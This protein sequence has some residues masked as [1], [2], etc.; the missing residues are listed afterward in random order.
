MTTPIRVL[1]C[2]DDR[3]FAEAVAANLNSRADVDVVA[4][5]GSAEETERATEQLDPHVLLVD[6]MLPD[7]D[8]LELA[9]TLLERFPEKKVIILTALACRQTA[10]AAAECGARAFLKKN[11]TLDEL[12]SAIS[13]VS[14]GPGLFANGSS[15]IRSRSS[16]RSRRPSR[17]V[18]KLTSREFEVLTLL[19]HGADSQTIATSLG[20]Q[21]NTVRTHVQ[22]ILTKL[23]VHSRLEAMALAVRKSLVTLDG[24]VSDGPEWARTVAT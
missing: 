8:G 6:V 22:S 7:G 17:Q 9:G 3:L 16:E 15:A 12:V 1:I 10:D 14:A 11:A 19:V 24:P 2:D 4:V 5:A 23:Q 21:A 18:A 13:A 20:I